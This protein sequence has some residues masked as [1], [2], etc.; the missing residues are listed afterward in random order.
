MNKFKIGLLGGLGPLSTNLF[1]GNLIKKIQKLDF[2]KSNKNFPKI[3]INSIPGVELTN[4][5][6]YK[7]DLEEY[8]NGINELNKFNS[9]I[10]AFICNSVHAHIDTIKQSTKIINFINLVDIVESYF[11]KNQKCKVCIL[12]MPTTINNK[13]FE[14]KNISYI[15][16]TENEQVELTSIVK[17]LNANGNIDKYISK[18]TPIINQK[19]SEGANIFLSACS[20]IS[21]ILDKIENI[22]YIDTL[23]LLSLHIVDEFSKHHYSQKNT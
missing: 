12:G 18:I 20:E 8:I 16:L 19:K 2:V 9:H 6:I 23:E 14:F 11:L 15:H 4:K 7:V 21:V 13:I 22:N 10:T 3:F 5:N 1:Y 17:N